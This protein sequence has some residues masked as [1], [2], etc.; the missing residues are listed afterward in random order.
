VTATTTTATAG[1][2]PDLAGQALTDEFGVAAR[3]DAAADRLTEMAAAATGPAW[4]TVLSLGVPAADPHG[5][6]VATPGG[7]RA[8]GRFFNAADARLAAVLRGAPAVLVLVLR[9]AAARWRGEARP[10]A[11]CVGL[12]DALILADLILEAAL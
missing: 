7:R 11:C 1:P 9:D 8:I 6:A 5:L 4:Q 2:A 10:A 3:L 12:A